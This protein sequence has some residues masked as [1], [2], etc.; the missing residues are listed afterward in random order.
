M[1]E[2][3][4]GFAG[5]RLPCS[6]RSA[7]QG[8]LSPAS[9]PS[10]LLPTYLHPTPYTPY[11]YSLHPYTHSLHPYSLLPTA[12]IP[13]PYTPEPSSLT[14]TPEPSSLTTK[15]PRPHLLNRTKLLSSQLLNQNQNPEF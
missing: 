2:Q 5:Q 8:S 1:L 7:G 6:S 11:P 15:L 14:Y 4:S 10:S 12:L 13:P 9:T 3:G